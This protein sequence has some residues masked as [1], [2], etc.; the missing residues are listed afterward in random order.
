[1]ADRVKAAQTTRIDPPLRGQPPVL[2]TNCGEELVA[3]ADIHQSLSINGLRAYEWQHLATGDPCCDLHPL[4]RPYDGWDA[5][6]QIEAARRARYEAEDREL[7]RIEPT[8]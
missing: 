6:R 8:P 5:T 2:C 1:M 3:V 4:G 7:D